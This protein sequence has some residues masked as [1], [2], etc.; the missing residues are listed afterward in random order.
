MIDNE[1]LIQ[2]KKDVA[3]E[4]SASLPAW[5]RKHKV[6][7][8]T[9][10]RLLEYVRS[11]VNNPDDHNLYE[12]LGV[13]RFFFLLEKYRWNAGKASH[14]CRFYECL[15][16]SGLNGRTR[17]KLT[18]VQC[19]FFCNIYG[20]MDE[21]GRRLFRSIT[22]FVPR[23]F[24]K[25]TSVSSMAVY[26]ML[27][28]DNNAQAYVGANSYDQAKICF[29]EIRN[30]MRDIDPNEKHTRVNREKIFF[31]DQGRDAMARCLTNNARTQDGLSAS[32]AILDE[33]A[34]ARDT[35]GKAGSA[36]KSVLTSSM[37]ARREPLTVVMTTASD[38]LDGPFARELEGIKAV[39]RG[40]L[41]N[42]RAFA[43]LFMPDIGDEDG[44]PHTWAKVQP[45][46]GV[47]VQKDYYA[48]EWGNAQMSADNMMVF[49]TKLLNIFATSERSSWISAEKAKEISVPLRIESLQGRPAA[50]V[51]IDLSEHDDFSA[52]SVGIYDRREKRFLF[53]TAYFF[54]E[55][56]LSSHP[57][58][59]LYRVWASEG[60]LILTKG[61]VIDYRAIVDYI[62]GINKY[63]AILK[64][65]YDPWKSLEVV[66]MLGAA[67]AKN[68]LKPVRQSYGY[69]TAPVES[70]EHGV[71]TGHVFINDNPINAYCFGNA[72]LDEDAME[73]RKP[74]KRS[75]NQK[76]DGVVTMLMCQR[77]F[78][79]YEG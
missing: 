24:S 72:V 26:D 13:K 4:L 68:V 40:E 8:D 50:M 75:H 21:D 57:N 39:L 73:N 47:T 34:Q 78:I 1:A 43:M 48:Q 20:M 11:V 59:A 6:V 23:K 54:P 38:V 53:H 9:D 66:N 17:Y 36:L 51:A 64:I 27:F 62:L 45:H 5:I 49:R 60:H 70:F 65:G 2:L 22:L 37:G 71:H 25:T 52:V 15:K 3:A 69:F 41:D 74:I 35:K 77:L 44:D 28:G 61:R 76:I 42:D 32:L 58:E 63:A 30:I 14:F 18:P 12:Q 16:F 29:D 56:A 31:K 7:W 55:C 19:F 10:A 79:D 33:Y 46:L 67:G